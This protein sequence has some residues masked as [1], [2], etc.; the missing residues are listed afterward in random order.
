MSRDIAH[1]VTVAGGRSIVAKVAGSGR[2]VL[3][4][5]GIPGVGAVW[6]E[7]SRL[8]SARYRVV[9]PDL[10][11]FGESS[12]AIDIETL[13]ADAQ[14]AAVLK[15]MD[16]LCIDEALVVGHDF[17]GPVAAHLVA[18]APERVAG[19]ILVSANTFGDTPIP[20]PL[21]GILWPGVGRAWER[22]I[23]SAPSLR[24]MV[25]QG[26]GDTTTR[27]DPDLYVG[28]EDQARAIRI[29]FG[30]ALRH[31][32][33]RYAPI[34]ELLG[35]VDTPTRVVWGDRD[36]FFPV[37]QAYRTAALIKS[38]SVTVLPGAGH[39]LPEER[40]LELAA[41]VDRLSFDLESTAYD[42]AR[43]F[44]PEVDRAGYLVPRDYSDSVMVHHLLPPPLLMRFF[45][46]H[47]LASLLSLAVIG[48][49]GRADSV[50][51]SLGNSV[52]SSVSF[53]LPDSYVIFSPFSRILDALTLL[54]T[55]QTIALLVSA[56]LTVVIWA[57]TRSAYS[58]PK[59]L[60]LGIA[61]FLVVALALEAAAAF[62]PR[63]MA[64]LSSADPDV[65]LIDF[66]S[67]T[68]TS[69]DV[70]K[71]YDSEMNRDWHM[72]GGFDIAYVTDHV[73]FAGAIAA[74]SN[75]PARA[76]DG[77]SLLTGVEGRY[78][79]IMSTIVLGISEAD[80]LLLNKRGNM[81]SGVVSAGVP[82]VTIIALPNRNLDS[83]TTQLLDSADAL[84]N[85]VAIE[86]IDAAPRGLAQFDREE[87]NIR[88]VAD[89]LGLFLV[90]ASNNHGYGRT[91]AAWNLMEVRGWRGRAPEEVARDI[92]QQL[93]ERRSDAVEIVQRTRPRVH[94]I[95]SAATL[96]VVA[97]QTFGSLTMIER[98]GWLAWI[99][100]PVLITARRA[101]F[102]L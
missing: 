46:R 21:S 39:F 78:H 71:G 85:L 11:G 2:V 43:D 58:L 41:E 54:S 37:E 1:R 20:F 34:T 68:G 88:R 77:T 92:E 12:R 82:P 56:A 33:S 16:D 89:E 75:N 65:V 97:W 31:L 86:L 44:S 30:S 84:P 42:S 61:S 40:P 99:W 67:H 8:L 23:F 10:V 57:A 94:G 51:D 102:R 90:A 64:A 19:L 14:A 29:I 13:W 66:H 15:L 5:H 62:F 49:T 22:M 96:P 101:S 25:K 83:V 100:I 95:A 4:L 38:A 76:G 9:V 6:A 17:G 81:L 87:A 45:R 80:S 48:L 59:R 98:V 52:A 7:V 79:R 74:R 91:V 53:V 32:E 3:L 24:M 72:S 55:Q 26:V 36:P 27:L 63:P 70:R 35:R 28:D 60:G 18:Q 50:T 93:R 69:H 47:W 73:K